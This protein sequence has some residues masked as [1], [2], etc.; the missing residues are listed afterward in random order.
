MS[1]IDIH[2]YSSH[3]YLFIYYF[4]CLFIYLFI[5]LFFFLTYLIFCFNFYYTYL[6]Y[7]SSSLTIYFTLFIMYPF[8]YFIMLL[9]RSSLC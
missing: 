9:T 8:H 5:Y 2:L 7:P 6:P 1:I 3:I 4:M